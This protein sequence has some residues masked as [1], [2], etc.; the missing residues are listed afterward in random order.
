M[1]LKI[2]SFS[3][4]LGLTGVHCVLPHYDTRHCGHPGNSEV[5]G[6]SVPG[7]GSRDQCFFFFFCIISRQGVPEY[8]YPKEEHTEK[9][10]VP[11][12]P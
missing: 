9:P 11:S 12:T 1:D 6:S 5:L 7:I 2:P 4:W 3:S 10:Q 8:E